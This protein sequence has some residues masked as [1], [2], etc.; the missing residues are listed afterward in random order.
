MPVKQ[1][2][3]MNGE[4]FSKGETID[5]LGYIRAIVTK[6]CLPCFDKLRSVLSA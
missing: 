6:I 2:D 3:N 1:W 5:M 4:P